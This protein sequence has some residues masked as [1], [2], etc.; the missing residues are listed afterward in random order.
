MNRDMT[1]A[2][3]PA[4]HAAFAASEDADSEGEEGKFYVWTEE[5][6]DALLGPDAA[7]FKEAYDVTGGGNWEGHTIL[8]RVTPRGT[9]EAE[10]GL[11]RSRRVLFEARAR[12]C[13]ARARRQGLGRL[14][15]PR[16]RGTMPRRRG[17]QTPRLARPRRFGVRVHSRAHE[18]GGWARASCLAA[19]PG[20]RRG[21]V[22]RS[23]RHGAGRASRCSSARGT[24]GG[25]HRRGSLPTRPS[26]CLQMKL[27][28]SSRPLSTPPTCRSGKQRG[29][30][31]RLTARRLPETA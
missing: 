9:D 23:G 2:C 22:G 10:A 19:E 18:R 14:E 25:S 3:T 8:H 1:A 17:L 31:A 27:D 4:G 11:S 15:R 6:I 20:D 30:V 16:Y 26:I 28:R 21:P 5:E 13:P 7:A 29:R 24:S 12:A